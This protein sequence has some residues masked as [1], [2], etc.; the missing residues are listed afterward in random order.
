MMFSSVLKKKNHYCLQAALKGTINQRQWIQ[1][2]GEVNSHI[3][4][5]RVALILASPLHTLAVSYKG[6]KSIRE[7]NSTAGKHTR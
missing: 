4:Q 3:P 7:S 2:P 5:A 6:N 1:S